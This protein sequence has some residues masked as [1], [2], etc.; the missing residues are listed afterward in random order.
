[1]RNIGTSTRLG[2]IIGFGAII[3]FDVIVSFGVIIVYNEY[4]VQEFGASFNGH[5]LSLGGPT[6]KGIGGPPSIGQQ[7][8]NGP[9]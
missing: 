7:P 4:S 3:G 6:G 1:L 8:M 5:N 9:Q 2:G